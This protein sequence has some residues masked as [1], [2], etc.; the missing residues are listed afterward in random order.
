MYGAINISIN[1]A[2]VRDFFSALDA[3][4]D[5]RH[6]EEGKGFHYCL[7]RTAQNVAGWAA[8]YTHRADVNKLR[9]MLGQPVISG[10]TASGRPRRRVARAT[11]QASRILAIRMTKRG[12][13]PRRIGYTH[14]QWQ[15]IVRKFVGRTIRSV[16][17]MR[18]GWLPAYR[19][20]TRKMHQAAE[21]DRNAA[22]GRRQIDERGEFA[23]HKYPTIGGCLPAYEASDGLCVEIF[24]QAVN[25]RNRTSW[26]EGLERYGRT[27]LERALNY[28]AGD[29]LLYLQKEMDRKAK[30]ANLA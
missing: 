19:E 18:A 27:G 12:K 29:M 28:K 14:E 30:E 4:V 1:E 17:F 5:Y 11:P 7:N 16:N 23:K 21:L 20:L 10:K 22:F 2:S 8:H 26:S 24:N 25:P 15:E 3:Y 6:E 13:N 9:A